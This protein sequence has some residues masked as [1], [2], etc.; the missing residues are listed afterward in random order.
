MLPIMESPKVPCGFHSLSTEMKENVFAFIR[1]PSD[2]R[3]VRLVNRDWRDVSD[4]V[5]W[6]EFRTTAVNA[7]DTLQHP[8]CSILASVRRLSIVEPEGPVGT[9]DVLPSNM[10][11]L[12]AALPKDQLEQFSCDYILDYE[13][14]KFILQRQGKLRNV[15]VTIDFEDES[16]LSSFD[17]IIDCLSNA[18]WLLLSIEDMEQ[19]DIFRSLIRGLPALKKISIY[20][21]GQDPI[22]YFQAPDDAPQIFNLTSLTLRGFDFLETPTTFWGLIALKNLTYLE[23]DN[24]KNGAPLYRDLIKSFS[25]SDGL[26]PSL[27]EMNIVLT[28]IERQPEEIIQVIEEFFTSFSGLVGSVIETSNYRL[29]DP[30]CFEHH[31]ASLRYLAIGTS[32]RGRPPYYSAAQVKALLGVCTNLTE[33]ALSFPPVNL[34]HIRGLGLDFRLHTH[35]SHSHMSELEAVLKSIAAHPRLRILRSLTM[36]LVDYGLGRDPDLVSSPVQYIIEELVGPAQVL[37]QNFATEVMRFLK[38]HGSDIRAFCTGGLTRDYTLTREYGQDSNGHC[39]PDYIYLPA[40]LVDARGMEHFSALPLADPDLE[41]PDRR[42]VGWT[43]DF[44]DSD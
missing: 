39:W 1:L 16:D 31:Y 22:L 11:N 23:F 35:G 2:R 21:D 17:E 19:S 25:A 37:M 4:N 44:Y 9:T 33:L 13:T 29:V 18:E 24:V 6:T 10:V 36:P 42:L 5:F 14:I 26:A 27:M 43:R 20:K 15:S 30:S 41:F 12:I 3:A 7:L 38:Q 32:W 8:S 28:C 34:G 40:R